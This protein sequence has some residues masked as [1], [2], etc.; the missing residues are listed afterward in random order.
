ML[1]RR[2]LS[3]PAFLMSY[4]VSSHHRILRTVPPQEIFI[5]I[6]MYD[7]HVRAPNADLSHTLGASN[8]QQ[9]LKYDISVYRKHLEHNWFNNTQPLI[10]SPYYGNIPNYNFY[11]NPEITH[12][13]KQE[14]FCCR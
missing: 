9:E 2:T 5:F 6:L 12:K 3:G 8:P 10:D 7:I 4:G 11:K 14:I 13:F 1:I